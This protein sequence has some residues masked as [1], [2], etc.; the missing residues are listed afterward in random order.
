LLISNLLSNHTLFNL[1]TSSSCSIQCISV[2]PL[3]HRLQTVVPSLHYTTF[4]QFQTPNRW[5][6][7]IP[8]TA[9]KL[10]IILNIT[11]YE[12]LLPHLP[13]TISNSHIFHKHSFFTLLKPSG[14][15][16]GAYDS[17]MSSQ[18]K[19]EQQRAPAV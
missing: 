12:V 10:A 13:V 1:T 14:G 11:I 6:C 16:R 15:H 19:V 4:A 17:D 2:S 7:S 3:F 8:I 9:H 18:A 5:V